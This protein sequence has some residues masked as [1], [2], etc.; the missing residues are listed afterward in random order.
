MRLSAHHTDKSI[1][2][3]YSFSHSLSL[4]LSPSSIQK[5]VHKKPV[6]ER[7]TRRETIRKGGQE[8]GCWRIHIPLISLSLPP[9]FLWGPGIHGRE[10][11]K[12]AAYPSINS[13]CSLTHTHILQFTGIWS[14]QSNYFE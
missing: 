14:K 3:S 1:F 2:I 9:R 13:S 8:V 10:Y 4:F 11:W 12:A 7:G 6:K 5:R